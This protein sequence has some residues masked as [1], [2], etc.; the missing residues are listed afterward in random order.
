MI[1]HRRP[2]RD[3]LRSYLFFLENPDKS[4]WGSITEEDEKG[5][6]KAVK[7]ASNYHGPIIEIG[8]LFG[9]TTNL[10]AS[11]KG[12]DVPLIAVENFSWNPFSL[13]VEAH[14]QF[15]RRTL[16][17]V[18]ENCST[19]LFEGNAEDFYSSNAS[20]KPSMIFIDAWHE[21][22]SVKKDIE[23]AVA[24][25]CPVISGHDYTEIHPGVIM[26]VK[27]AFGDRVLLYGSVWIH[28]N[29]RDE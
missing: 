4:A 18:L 28:H 1:T 7:L 10:I 15:T 24:T 22:D 23:R 13:P 8:A 5:I 2:I 11:L 6:E 19:Q 25:G 12:K 16:R 3:L 17:Y 26:A 20:L 21:Y 9:H 14:R 27:E 29:E